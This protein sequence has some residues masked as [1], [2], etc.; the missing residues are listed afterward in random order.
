MSTVIKDS[1]SIKAYA[2]ALLDI[3]KAE[4]KLAE[5]KNDLFQVS[6]LFKQQ[7]DLWSF[8]NDNQMPADKKSKALKEILGDNVQDL[9]LNQLDFLIDQGKQKLI[10]DFVEKF[11]QLVE[12]EENKVTAEVTTAVPIEAAEQEK[13]R[14]KLKKETGKEIELR[15]IVDKDIV[16]GLVIKIGDRV[17]DASVRNRLAQLHGGI[18]SIK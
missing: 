5:I 14:A 15:L 17:V 13:I 6:Q 16:A 8:L 1:T 10:F 11:N 3:A 2:K 4:G 12:I 7:S 18:T 9:T